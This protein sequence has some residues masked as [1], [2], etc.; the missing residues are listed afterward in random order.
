MKKH[1]AFKGQSLAKAEKEKAERQVW[2]QGGIS[3]QE[4]CAERI[5]RITCTR[6]SKEDSSNLGK[7]SLGRE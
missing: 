3:R 7:H 6:Q 2:G 5:S 4:G 1:E